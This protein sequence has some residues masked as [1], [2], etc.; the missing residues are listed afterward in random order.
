MVSKIAHKK[1]KIDVVDE[2]HAIRH[3]LANVSQDKILKEAEG[4][5]KMI[6]RSSKVVK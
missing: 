3:R 2:L 1:L 5:R 6:A 4:V